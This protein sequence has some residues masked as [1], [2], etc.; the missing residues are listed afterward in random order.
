MNL[1]ISSAPALLIGLVVAL[2]SPAGAWGHHSP[3]VQFQALV[4]ATAPNV[5]G[6]IDAGEWADTPSYAVNF[7]G[8]VGTVRFKHAG[9]YLYGALNVDDNGVGSKATFLFDDDHDGVKTPARTS[10]PSA[11]AAVTATSTTARPEVPARA[12]T[13]TGRRWGRTRP[14]AARR[15]RRA[16]DGRRRK[17]DLRVPAPTLLQRHGA[18]LLPHTREHGGRAAAIPVGP[19][20]LGPRERAP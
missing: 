2:V 16:G 17:R 8:M 19:L 10:F 4:A 6:Q 9:G 12:T 1:R 14:G 20:L 7:G 11:G 13:A 18:R 5:N 15:T 3:P